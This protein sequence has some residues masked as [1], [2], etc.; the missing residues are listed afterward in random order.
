[1]SI[2]TCVSL[3]LLFADLLVEMKRVGICGS[4]VH[5]WLHGYIGDFIVGQSCLMGHESSGVVK[6][7]GEGVTGFKAGEVAGT[8]KSWRVCQEK[9]VFD[10]YAVQS[11]M[12]PGY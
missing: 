1:M 6:A 3:L 10:M 2:R 9:G 4:D 11:G 8:M 5:Y 12:L 7:V